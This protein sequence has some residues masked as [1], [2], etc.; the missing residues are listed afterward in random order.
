[1]RGF[2]S[3][4]KRSFVRVYAFVTSFTFSRE[5]NLG[6]LI[7]TGAVGIAILGFILAQRDWDWR[8]NKLEKMM[9]DLQAI[10]KEQQNCSDQAKELLKESNDRWL[11][12]ANLLQRENIR[13]A[14]LARIVTKSPQITPED[15]ALLQDLIKYEQLSYKTLNLARQRLPAQFLIADRERLYFSIQQRFVTQERRLPE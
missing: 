4:L 13:L 2:L 7:A 9:A 5:I 1:M 14:S 10:Q 6:N 15:K 11:A 3:L 12:Q 8:V